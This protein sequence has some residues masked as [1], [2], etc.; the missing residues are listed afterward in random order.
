MLSDQALYT[1]QKYEYSDESLDDNLYMP[2]LILLNEQL[3]CEIHN[4]LEIFLNM[5]FFSSI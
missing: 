3:S 1:F 4:Q 2:L 5:R